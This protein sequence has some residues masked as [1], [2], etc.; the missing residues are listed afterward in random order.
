VITHLVETSVLTRRSRAAIEK[1]LAPYWEGD[2]LARCAITDLEVCFSASNA[3]EWDDLHGTLARLHEI[4]V[5]PEILAR[6]KAVQRLLADRGLKGRKVPD[7][8]IAAA[9]ELT[10][11][12]LLHY[13]QDFDFIGSI[14]G[15][16]HS[17][18]VP[19]GTVD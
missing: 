3:R 12:T 19:R 10:G 2:T 15:Q 14:T 17:W 13:D 6:A 4:E 16:P 5:T 9:A 1:A 18:I 8:I 11:L 7:L